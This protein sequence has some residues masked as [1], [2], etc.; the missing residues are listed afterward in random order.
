M[1]FIQI[2]F[3]QLKRLPAMCQI[4]SVDLILLRCQLKRQILR[5]DVHKKKYTPSKKSQWSGGVIDLWYL[6]WQKQEKY[7]ELFPIS[8]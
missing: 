6:E 3:N 8:Y 2:K 5:I 7:T 1:F 4:T